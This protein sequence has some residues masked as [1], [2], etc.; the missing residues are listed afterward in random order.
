VS[1][2]SGEALRDAD[3]GEMMR[4]TRL[5]A[6]LA[7]AVP[8]YPESGPHAPAILAQEIFLDSMREEVEHFLAQTDL[9]AE[10]DEER[11]L[12]DQLKLLGETLNASDVSD[13]LP[14]APPGPPLGWLKRA[15]R[16]V[17]WPLFRL[18]LGPRLQRQSQLNT[19]LVQFQNLMAQ[20]EARIVSVQRHYKA[21]QGNLSKNLMRILDLLHQSDL[22][23][24]E[25]MDLL[26]EDLDRRILALRQDVR[27]AEAR[28][29][30]G[31]NGS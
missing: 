31:S 22:R 13:L 12:F 24:N 4:K 18:V 6:P 30:E 14:N 15:L 8:V 25:K 19:T 23:L 29:S 20:L 10:I 5:S 3:I 28:S 9:S 16:R 17:L 1:G 21:H 27:A 7:P 26:V 11:L 2:E